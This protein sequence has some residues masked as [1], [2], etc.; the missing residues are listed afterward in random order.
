MPTVNIKGKAKHFPYTE[1]GKELA[2]IAEK[3]VAPAKKKVVKVMK[4]AKAAR[5]KVPFPK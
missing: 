5:A 2:E 4:T 3:K 1:K